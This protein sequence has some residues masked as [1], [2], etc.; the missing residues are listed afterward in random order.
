GP[1]A[2]EPAQFDIGIK[3]DWLLFTL[4]RNLDEGHPL[5]ACRQGFECP[6]N[7]RQ[8][9]FVTD[10]QVL[11]RLRQGA[12]DRPAGADNIAKLGMQCRP[13]AT[14]SSDLLAGERGRQVFDSENAQRPVLL[15][16]HTS[17]KKKGVLTMAV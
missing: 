14:R 9:R 17:Q 2:V 1:V 15:F 12:A 6:R 8:R 7:D 3:P 13:S 4:V 11:V 5:R 16:D 10:E